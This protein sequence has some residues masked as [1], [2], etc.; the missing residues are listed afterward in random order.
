MLLNV[1]G[2]PF[3][4]L[5]EDVAYDVERQE[6]LER[7]GWKVYRILYSAYKR[8]PSDEI[9][10]MVNFIEKNT[11][12]EK[13][14]TLSEVDKNEDI[15]EAPQTIAF[16]KHQLYNNKLEDEA[17]IVEKEKTF[18]NRDNIGEDKILRYFNL[19][20]DGTYLLE[21]NENPT[22]T[23]IP[24]KESEKG[25]YLLQGYDNGRLNKILI[26]ALLSKRIDKEYKNGLNVD[27]TLLFLE[28]IKR[29]E[30]IALHFYENG[31]KKFKAHLTEGISNRK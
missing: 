8:N 15:E 5:P 2:D 3:H 28:I 10:K 30:I 29:D 12:K 23:S 14:I 13:T 7:V 11:K 9:E 18:E 21:R 25:G 6:F 27:A 1:D 24:I 26:S 20:L 31:I 17:H 4:S 22:A 19:N 16:P